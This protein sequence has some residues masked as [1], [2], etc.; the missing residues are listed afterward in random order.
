MLKN[1]GFLREI[2]IVLGVSFSCFT[3]NGC[4][5]HIHPST[6]RLSGEV[7]NGIEKA[8][9][10]KKRLIR[11]FAKE[12]LAHIDKVIYEIWAPKKIAGYLPKSKFDSEV[13]KAKGLDRSHA[14]LKKFL[15]ITKMIDKKRNA[16]RKGV[17]ATERKML[18]ETDE[19]FD[20]LESMSN[21]VTL[22]IKAVSES[23]K[24]EEELIQKAKNK[25]PILDRIDEE[26][27]KL[28]KKLEELL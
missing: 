14:L 13:C 3:F 17:Y 22:T 2:F 10:S 27:E 15:F 9:D 12:S 25:L 11:R 1:R 23:Q 20:E 7:T 24:F 4:G 16:L 18:S 6:V 8:Q 26:R 5:A 21:M 28:N 19:Y